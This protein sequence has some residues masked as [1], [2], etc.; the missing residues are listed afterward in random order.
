MTDQTTKGHPISAVERDTGIGRDTLRIWERRYGFPAPERDSHG[1]RIYPDSQIK[2]LQLIR[3]LMDQGW[4]PGQIV[5]MEEEALDALA[6]GA[7]DSDDKADDSISSV[8][9]AVRAHDVQALDV[10]L[11]SALDQ[12]GTRRLVLDVLAPAAERVG[13][14]WAAGN[15]EIFEEHLFTRCVTRLLDTLCDVSGPNGSTASPILLATLPG[16]P[17]AL[18]L[19]MVDTLL[20]ETGVPTVNLGTEIPLEQIAQAIEQVKAGTVALSF[21]SSYPYAQIRRNLEDLRS[22][23]SPEIEVWIGG[24][25]ARRLKRLPEGVLRKELEH[26]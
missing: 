15:I 11:K 17:H 22:R 14:G 2:R 10:L 19:L 1:D 6:A 16:E 9:D 21:S 24:G 12:V 23:I 20:H 5:G 8:V 13:T 4:R 25:G 26:L 18:G 7:T 3:R